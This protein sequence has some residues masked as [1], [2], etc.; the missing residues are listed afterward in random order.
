MMRAISE[1]GQR[2][3]LPVWRVVSYPSARSAFTSSSPVISRGSRIVNPESSRENLFAHEVEPYDAGAASFIEM[4]ANGIE[5]ID[6]HFFDR[7]GLSENGFTERPCGV[8]A[9]R[10]FFDDKDQFVHRGIE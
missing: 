2:M 8:A 4:A 5:D 3:W 7:V 6:P 9:F 1:G 10:G